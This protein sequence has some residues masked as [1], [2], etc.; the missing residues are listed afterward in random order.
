MTEGLTIDLENSFIFSNTTQME[1][2][3]AISDLQAIYAKDPDLSVGVLFDFLVFSDHSGVTTTTKQI[4]ASGP[5][6]LSVT[7]STFDSSVDFRVQYRTSRERNQFL[8]SA[9]KTLSIYID[10]YS[11]VPTIEDLE[12]LKNDLTRTVE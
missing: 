6:N 7:N 1:L 4:G 3:N 11:D 10:G 9:V 2:V 12:L 5:V 8:K